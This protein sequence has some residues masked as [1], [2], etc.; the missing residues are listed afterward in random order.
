MEIMT[1]SGPGIKLALRGLRLKHTGFIRFLSTAPRKLEAQTGLHNG[2]SGAG[3][4]L[5]FT[6]KH[7]RLPVIAEA[8]V[9]DVRQESPAVKGVTLKIDNPKFTFRA[10]QWVDMFIPGIETV[11]GFSM[12]S[13]PNQLAERGT[14]DLGIK[15]SKW[16]PAFWVHNECKVGS[17]VALRVGGDFY[18]APE[19]GDP[20]SDLLLVA[21]GVGLNP[22]AS[23]VFHASYLHKL[24]QENKEE[25]YCPGKI[26]LLYSAKTYEDILYKPLLDAVSSLHPQIEIKY[27]TTRKPPPASNVT[28]GH[29]TQDN[30]RSALKVLDTS[31][32]RTF[33]CGPPPMIENI[34]DNLLVCGLSRNQILY[35]KWW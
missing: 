6:A 28:C 11:G 9:T 30:L 12:Y 2:V 21:G 31:T 32:L 8:V 23:M 14:I 5:Q 18:Y 7:S 16:P 26:L 1:L 4:H 25:E 19:V 33:V 27:F 35:E 10:G 29:I 24:Y 3:K 20:P 13:A 17:T 22:L 34:K 15:F